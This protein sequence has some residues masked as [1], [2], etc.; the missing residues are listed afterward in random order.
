MLIEPTVMA[1]YAD[2]VADAALRERLMA[3]I[4]AELR[5][6]RHVLEVIYGGPLSEKRPNV[7]Q[8]IALRQPLLAQL[9]AEQIKLL[10]AWRADRSEALLT[11]LLLTVNAIANGLGTTG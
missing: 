5:R 3:L 2:L 4:A 11:Q 10:R 1:H 6:T 8:E 9:H 7:A